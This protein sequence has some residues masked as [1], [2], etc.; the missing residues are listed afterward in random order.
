M[1][2]SDFKGDEALEIMA[3][4]I[5]PASEIIN[6]EETKKLRTNK[7]KLAQHILK[8]HKAE[9]L[10]IYEVLYKEKGSEATPITLL[11]MVMEILNDKELLSLFTSQGQS[12]DQERSGSVTGNIKVE[13]R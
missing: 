1:K 11:K 6:D 4:V 13:G 8:N 12:E 3:D 10:K 7:A 9:V 5:E 2:L